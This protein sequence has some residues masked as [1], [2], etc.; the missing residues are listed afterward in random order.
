LSY[1]WFK[2]LT[3]SVPGGNTNNLVINNISS[4]DAGVYRVQV[5]NAFG[6][7]FSTNA[8]L[9]VFAG[10]NQPPSTNQPPVTNQAPVIITQPK[11]TTAVIG[12][13]ATFNV[14]ASGTAP[15]SYQWFPGPDQF[16]VSGRSKPARDGRNG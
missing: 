3:N 14:T 8:T 7:V 15:L 9:I 5:A 13:T 11:S 4:N 16:G 12:G 10:T 6:S 2:D 1:Q